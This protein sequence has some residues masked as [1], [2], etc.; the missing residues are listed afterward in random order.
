MKILRFVCITIVTVGL[1]GPTAVYAGPTVDYTDTVPVN[2]WIDTAFS[3]PGFPNPEDHGNAT[4]ASWSHTNPYTGDYEA[5]LAAGDILGATLTISAY[6]VEAKPL[7]P[8]MPGSPLKSDCVQ[9]SFTDKDGNSHELGYLALTGNNT[10][11]S[12]TFTLDPTWLDGVAVT[13]QVISIC[14]DARI[15]TSV[16]IVTANAPCPVVPAPGAILLAGIGAVL[17]GWLRRRRAL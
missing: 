2:Q 9:V 8:W 3:F 6:D 1:A 14:D 4:Q 10:S 15:D 5:A 13:S 12:T 16:L 17:I 7:F 11:G